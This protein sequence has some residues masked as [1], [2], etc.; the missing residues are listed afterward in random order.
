MSG[1]GARMSDVTITEF[2]LA[3]IAERERSVDFVRD[4]IP[5]EGN[6]GEY[7]DPDRMLA[8]CEA[9]RR[10][11]ELHAERDPE[12]LLYPGALPTCIIC[13]GDDPYEFPC[14][15]VKAL[16]LPFVDHA[17]YDEAWRI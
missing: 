11:V 15:T 5:D 10:I 7:I 17:D 8:E 9:K 4:F 1:V 14:D 16:A 6:Q 3:R 13:G 2:L 12:G